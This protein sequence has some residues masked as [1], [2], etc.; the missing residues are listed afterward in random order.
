[1]DFYTDFACGMVSCPSASLVS[2]DCPDYT[3]FMEEVLTPLLKQYEPQDVYNAD[4]TS[5]YY[6]CLP[7]RTYTFEH[8]RVHVFPIWSNSYW[9]NNF[10]LFFFCST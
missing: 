8:E 10:S 3:Q 5:L 1:M 6:K 2:L 4:E 9:S 7:D